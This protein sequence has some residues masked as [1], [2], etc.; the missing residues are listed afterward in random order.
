MAR[1]PASLVQWV[2]YVARASPFFLQKEHQVTL[3]AVGGVS[4]LDDIVQGDTILCWLP[5]L[6][7]GEE[8]LFQ[9]SAGCVSVHTHTQQLVLLILAYL[10]FRL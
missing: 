5:L 3:E 1:P 6:E 9:L 2:M 4:L 8:P 10:D 7:E